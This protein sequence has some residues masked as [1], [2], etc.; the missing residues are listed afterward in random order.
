MIDQYLLSLMPSEKLYLDRI[1]KREAIWVPQSKP[2]WMAFLSRA[3]ELFY[4]GAAGG[5][6][7][8]LVL[9]MAVEAHQHSAIFRRV[10]PN[11]RGMFQRAQNLIGSY[12]R[13]SGTTWNFPGGRTL[14]FGAVQYERD[15]T[16]WQGRPH[17]LKAFDELPEFS[18]SQY[19]FITGWTRTTDATQRTRVIA[20]GN[21]PTDEFRLL[22][23]SLL[24]GMAGPDLLQTCQRRRA[25]LV[26]YD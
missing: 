22:G 13:P 26:C 1:H 18:E 25:A 7:S 3:D 10:Y 17:D 11:L 15:K 5:G 21:P 24:A 12:G 6:K 9:G 8:D 4:G 2:Q 19:K 23:Y 16:N 20:T 14:E